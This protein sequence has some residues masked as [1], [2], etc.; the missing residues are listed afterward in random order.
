M[1]AI[2]E[3]QHTKSV[4]VVPV[5]AACATVGEGARHRDTLFQTSTYAA[6][7]GGLYDGDHTIGELK[8][9]GDFGHGTFNGLDGEMLVLDGVVY[10]IRPGGAATVAPDDTR[11]PFAAV[12]PFESDHTYTLTGAHNYAALQ[13]ELDSLIPDHGRPYAIRI[14]GTFAAIQLRAPHKATPPYPPL[15]EALATQ[16]IRDDTNVDGTMVGFYFPKHMTGLQFPGYHFHFLT[17][18]RRTG[19]HVLAVTPANVT[20]A[21]DDIL[22]FELDRL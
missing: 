5:L 2:F 22:H 1:R 20:I 8:R 11:T 7:A 3:A 16:V 13:A 15:A 12:T 4:A 19:G 6:L 14:T 10:Q 21:I 17:A 18:D 9:H